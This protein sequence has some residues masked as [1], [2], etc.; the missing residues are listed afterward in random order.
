MGDVSRS[1]LT[2]PV[3][4]AV[5]ADLGSLHLPQMEALAGVYIIPIIVGVVVFLTSLEP[6]EIVITSS[7]FN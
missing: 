6:L 7:L 1:V 4:T 3:A 2:F 5:P